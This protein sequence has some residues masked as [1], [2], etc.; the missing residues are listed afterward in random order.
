[1]SKAFLKEDGE[2]L[3]EELVVEEFEPEPE[4]PGR[5]Y[6][7]KEGFERLQEELDRLWSVERPKVTEEVSVAAAHGDRSENAEYQYGKQKLRE[8]DR[9][10]RFLT[11]RLDSLTVVE[12]TPEQEG[13]VFFGAWVQVEDEEGETSVYR[14]VGAD[15]VD[16]KS[17][18]ISVD[19]P[20][21]KALLGKEVD[22]EVVVRRP[23]G[24]TT[25]TILEVSYEPID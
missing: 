10:I 8:I 14:I 17:G 9:R 3:E 18:R 22:D 13:K 2:G 11:K 25:L 16:P 23:K 4:R 20:L 15:E 7:T 24:E 5:R 21:A 19:A 12:A 1:M 6:I